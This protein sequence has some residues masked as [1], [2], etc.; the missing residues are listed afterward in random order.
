MLFDNVMVVI[1]CM[2]NKIVFTSKSR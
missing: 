1:M 2:E